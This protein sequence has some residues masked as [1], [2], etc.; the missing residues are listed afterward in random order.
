MPNT[1]TIRFRA[2][3][4]RFS[5]GEGYKVPT[6]TT[7]HYSFG[8]RDTVAITLG[9]A[10]DL[11]MALKRYG[12][13]LPGVV[14]VDPTNVTFAGDQSAWTITPLGKGFMADVSATFPLIRQAVTQ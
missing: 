13:E 9:T 14:W 10:H 5:G 8:E 4:A 1:I 7:S 11:P 12:V 2:K 6:L 3:R